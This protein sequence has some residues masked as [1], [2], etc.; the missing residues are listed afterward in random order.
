MSVRSRKA[1]VVPVVL[2]TPVPYA[3][4][5]NDAS[6]TAGN[7]S[8][9]NDYFCPACREPVVF[10][11]TLGRLG[12]PRHA[13]QRPCPFDNPDVRRQ[14]AV[15]RMRSYLESLFSG[16]RG[17]WPWVTHVCQCRLEGLRDLKEQFSGFKPGDAAAGEPDFYLLGH[18]G[19]TVL[20]LFIRERGPVLASLQENYQHP[21]I[22][23]DPERALRAPGVWRLETIN[24]TANY[25]KVV[26]P[27]C[28]VC[29]A[30][31]SDNK[32]TA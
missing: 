23:I 32:K 16:G 17:L 9:S 29:G 21:F 19:R 2:G 25:R 6:V 3:I 4:D 31:E 7:F 24:G 10:D 14:H 20:S 13:R 1:A 22:V 5:A 15:K 12:Q 28:P 26:L 27:P 11:K 18:T 8:A 30:A